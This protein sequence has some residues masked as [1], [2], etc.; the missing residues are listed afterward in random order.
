[1]LTFKKLVWAAAYLVVL[2][3]GIMFLWNFICP[4]LF[5]FPTINYQQALALKLLVSLLLPLGYDVREFKE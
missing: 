5:G 2:S 3:A 1:M 4:P